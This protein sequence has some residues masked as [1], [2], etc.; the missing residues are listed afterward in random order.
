MKRKNV[1]IGNIIRLIMQQKGISITDF[2]SKYHCNRTH[3]YYI[4]KQRDIYIKDLIRI[5]KILD[6]D[7]LQYYIEGKD[8][9]D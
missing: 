5:E 2:A 4:F 7:L 9:G 8:D 6:C 1:H 3:V